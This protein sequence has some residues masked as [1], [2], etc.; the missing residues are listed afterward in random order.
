MAVTRTFRPAIS[1]VRP[2]T[3]ERNSRPSRRRS[4]Q[5]RSGPVSAEA[6]SASMNRCIASCSPGS[7]K[8]SRRMC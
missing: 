2:R 5:T 6:A 7:S 4:R 8:S 3:S 1:T